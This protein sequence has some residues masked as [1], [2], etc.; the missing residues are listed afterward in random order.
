M[1]SIGNTAVSSS[2]RMATDTGSAR[3]PPSP[4]GDGTLRADLVE[5]AL[6]GPLARL[7]GTSGWSFLD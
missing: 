1:T 7:L 3:I 5:C 4:K 6:A 2:G